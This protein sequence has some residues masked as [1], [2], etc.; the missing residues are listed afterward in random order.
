MP[1]WFSELIEELLFYGKAEREIQ[2]IGKVRF[3]SVGG[4]LDFVVYFPNG[5]IYYTTDYARRVLDYET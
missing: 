4:L 5:T 2:Y 1:K 3:V